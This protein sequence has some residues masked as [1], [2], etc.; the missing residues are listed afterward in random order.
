[1]RRCAV[2]PLEVRLFRKPDF[3]PGSVVLEGSPANKAK[4]D[5]GHLMSKVAL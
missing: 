1:M 5:F 4:P 3:S 2:D